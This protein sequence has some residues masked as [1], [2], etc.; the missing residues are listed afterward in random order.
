MAMD[1]I[2]SALVLLVVEVTLPAVLNVPI[3]VQ[4]ISISTTIIFI[5]SHMAAE[6]EEKRREKGDE[7]EER[8]VI[9]GDRAFGF[10][11]M[12]SF[13]L[14]SLFLAFQY[15]PKEWVSFCL[16]LYGITFGALALANV[17]SL[18]AQGVPGYS[19]SV[20]SKEFKLPRDVRISVL[21]IL[22]SIVSMP[23][24]AWYYKRR[25]WLPNNILG[26]S[27]ALSAVDVLAL[28]DFKSGAVLL[29]GLFVYDIFWVFGSESVFGSNV[30]VS[31]ARNFDGPIKLIFPRF[32]GA[33]SRD[34]SMLGLGDIVIPGLFVALLLRFDKHK[35]R[36]HGSMVG[37]YRYFASG[38]LAY[39]AGLSATY[40]ALTVFKAAQPALLYLVPA[41]LCTSLGLALVTGEA[42]ELWTYTEV[43]E[44][45][46]KKPTETKD[47]AGSKATEKTVSAEESKKDQ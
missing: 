25:S 38:L 43:E 27:L 20:L 26:S 18:F 35:D 46:E 44:K 31:V 16:T 9:S 40:I 19:K 34:T 22:T 39:I 32:V 37:R 42:K 13:A 1:P 30:M 12:A 28:G 7:A 3:F 47:K 8:D 33:T 21:K 36:R 4:M 6:R 5:A 14:F 11:V 2:S 45:D 29:L 41:A 24:A 15:L 23:F 17:L 10:P